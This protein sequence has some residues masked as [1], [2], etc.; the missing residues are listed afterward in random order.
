MTPVG[1]NGKKIVIHPGSGS[2]KK[3][4]PFD[5]WLDLFIHIRKNSDPN[6]DICFLLG[7][8]EEDMVT[9]I[10]HAGEMYDA[11]IVICPEKEELLSILNSANLYIGH[12]S[13]V[14]HLAA[15]LGIKTIALFKSSSVK[16][17]HP[18]GPSVGVIAP[19]SSNDRLWDKVIKE[20][21]NRL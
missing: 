15:M 12:D 19:D 1:I 14:T 9:V 18:L 7:P 11:E 6:M 16:Q 2:K 8:V 17:W 21:I 20:V 3:N 4:Y 13:G 5:F 10:K